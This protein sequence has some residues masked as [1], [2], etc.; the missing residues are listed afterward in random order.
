MVRQ[1]VSVKPHYLHL[2]VAPQ[3]LKAWL[4]REVVPMSPDELAE[5]SHRRF[6]AIQAILSEKRGA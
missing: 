6:K 5:T 1:L 3:T 4:E 2:G